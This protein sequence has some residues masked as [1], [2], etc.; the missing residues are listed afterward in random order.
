MQ[1]RDKQIWLLVTGILLL[2]TILLT[3]TSRKPWYLMTLNEKGERYYQFPTEQDC[4]EAK[5]YVDMTSV[6]LLTKCSRAK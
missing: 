3:L 1:D 5:A 2:S 4:L 6:Y